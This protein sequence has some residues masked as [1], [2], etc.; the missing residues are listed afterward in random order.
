MILIKKNPFAYV[1]DVNPVR[2]AE[3]VVPVDGNGLNPL[4][5]DPWMIIHPPI[6]FT[7]Y[8]STMILFAFAMAALVRKE[9][10][11]WIREVF[12]FAIFVVLSLGT[13]IILGGYWA[14]TTLGWGGYWGWDPV[15]NSS[16]IPWLASLAFLHGAVIQSRQGGLKR[17]NIAIAILTF[18]LVLY[19]SF[20][21]RS[22]ILSDFSVHS[23][24]TSVLYDYLV[25]FLIFFSALAL[26]FFVLGTRSNKTEKKNSKFLTRE[27]F[28]LFGLLSLLLSAI[29]TFIGTSTPLFTQI[30]LENPS[31]VSVDYYNLLN[32]P[33]ALLIGIFLS[34]SPLLSW[35][36]EKKQLW[37][38]FILHI[39]L[40]LICS[41]L[42]YFLGLRDI[43]PLLLFAFFVFAISVNSRIV[44]Q[45]LKRK[46]W[47]IGGYLS[48]VGIGLMI[49]G[50]TTSSEYA[51][52]AKIALPIGDEKTVLNY[53][54]TYRGFRLN[55]ENKD[56]AVIE[57]QYAGLK[58]L[59]ATPKFYWSEFNQAYMRNP[60]VHNLWL[61]DLYVSPIQ[62]VPAEDVSEPHSVNIIRKSTA[63]F[64]E[65]LFHFLGYEMTEHEDQSGIMHVSAVFD[66][67]LD[68]QNYSVSPALIVSNN[69]R[70]VIPVKLPGTKRNMVIQDINIEDDSII[71]AIDRAVVESN[72]PLEY[73]AIEI[74]EKPL[75]NILWLG[76][77]IMI[78]GLIIQLI[79][80]IKYKTI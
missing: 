18:L 60:S 47:G 45:M 30:L 67:K 6:L 11:S 26:V 24:S 36:H 64:E 73:L 48:H 2:F 55:K 44:V 76:T 75:I 52:T 69:E 35:K 79:H 21:T 58:T 12:P 4:L 53:N 13:G 7:G 15:E 38:G 59:E 43:I 62:V 23:F 28:M 56:E 25:A 34:V 65:Y 68:G 66:V 42:G 51:K 39:I 50:I 3:G 72:Q 1:W 49:I 46:Q 22:G 37:K 80:R 9:F 29:F 33:V 17:T 78:A 70:Q 32:T 71:L 63:Y 27:T 31:D 14:Y 20:L 54:M 61:K 40:V 16:L 74:T 41:L 5:Q 8:S 10:D 57:I 19:G 77:V